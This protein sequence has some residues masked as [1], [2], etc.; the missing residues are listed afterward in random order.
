MPRRCQDSKVVSKGRNVS[1]KLANISLTL[2]GNLHNS[3]LKHLANSVIEQ[4]KA[5]R[6][7]LPVLRV[8]PANVLD[9]R[10]EPST[11]H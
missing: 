8:T 10:L 4:V 5:S 6:L 1:L 3:K 7:E 9:L 2:V 11:F